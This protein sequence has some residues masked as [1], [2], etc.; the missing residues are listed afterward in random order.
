MK[1][2]YQVAIL[3][4][5]CLVVETANF[6]WN[7]FFK[8]NGSLNTK[9]YSCRNSNKERC[10]CSK[11]CMNLNECCIDAF[12]NT[13]YSEAYLGKYLQDFLKKSTQ[14]PKR[15]CAPGFPLVGHRTKHYLM[16]TTCLS[17]ASTE[18]VE[19]CKNI[20]S[21][22]KPVKSRR[23]PDVL[24]R[25]T[26]CAKCNME[27]EIVAVDV[28]GECDIVDP[29]VYNSKGFPK[30]PF[31]GLEGCFFNLNV[32]DKLQ[33]IHNHRHSCSNKHKFY[34]L[35]MAY[36]GS[37][38]SYMNFHC[39]LCELDLTLAQRIE[40]INNVHTTT[41]STFTD[42]TLPP[43]PETTLPTIRWSLTIG[44]ADMSIATPGGQRILK[45]CPAGEVYVPEQEKC[46][47]FYCTAGY[48]PNHNSKTCVRIPEPTKSTTTHRKVQ[49]EI[50][51][52]RFDECLTRKKTN[53]VLEFKYNFTSIIK[54]RNTTIMTPSDKLQL[55]LLK[56]PNLYSLQNFKYTSWKD[57]KV[58]LEN[59]SIFLNNSINTITITSVQYQ[60]I[61][62]LHGFDV[63]R[64]FE[65]NKLCINPTVFN[66]AEYNIT[67][68][69]GVQ[70]KNKTYNR[71]D[72]ISYLIMKESNIERNISI[73][74][75][76]YM[77]STC[78]L[79]LVKSAFMISENHMLIANNTNK[80]WLPHEYRPLQNGI[81]ICINTEG[82]FHNKMTKNWISELSDAEDYIT[83]IVGALS[84][85]AYFTIIITFTMLK[86]MRSIPN[87]NIA[88]L[89]TSLFLADTLFLSTEKLHV[90]ENACK[91]IAVA[92]HW[93]LL[94]AYSW[95]MIITF[96]M[97]STFRTLSLQSSRS[98]K[99][100][101]NYCVFVIAVPTVA[102][103]ITLSLSEFSNINIGY[104]E[105]S[106][107]WIKNYTALL[108]SY[109]IPVAAQVLITISLL[110][111]VLKILYFQKKT[112][113]AV[114]KRKNNVDLTKVALKL[115]LLLG[116]I[117][118]VGFFQIKYK[119]ASARGVSFNAITSL[120]YTIFR[121]SR[122]VL[123]LVTVGLSRQTLQIYKK[124]T[125]RLISTLTKSSSNINVQSSSVKSVSRDRV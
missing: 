75:K 23:N 57:L 104:G 81:G 117:E 25:N 65:N 124:T 72:Y 10:T 109:L 63:T 108:Y 113:K 96:E 9:Q 105:S 78:P 45:E 118:V 28:S 84:I 43:N 52:T 115:V 83:A 71:T 1:A 34:D 76:F 5:V 11:N 121:S 20:T 101:W 19:Q 61:T 62:Q 106:Y 122:G 38:A 92:L 15:T 69:C 2:L 125:F 51:T 29:S 102:V 22:F 60:Q 56:R 77:S 82:N 24:Y 98:E 89:C 66:Q 30:N 114:L 42:G 73:C 16:V 87:Y 119:N 103:G 90:Y 26:Y 39:M 21:H 37:I 47:K 123:V 93:L 4:T 12:W 14:I 116:L 27:K 107:C 3:L 33:C 6:P 95:C 18:D 111:Y 54:S 8:V 79:Q 44:A 41:K 94:S 67:D 49:N 46:T 68:N 120:L 100:I 17:E 59:I 58:S 13:S 85:L 70:G 53:I 86:E 50:N 64:S 31:A 40:K 32:H 48:E 97:A 99:R 7:S 112:T 110:L 74:K 88:G 35:C 55:T 91:Y 36:K 80:T